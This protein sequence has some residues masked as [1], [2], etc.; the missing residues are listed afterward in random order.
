MKFY[1]EAYHT[2]REVRVAAI[3]LCFFFFFNF[4]SP[5]MIYP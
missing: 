1:E 4:V 5:F 3:S 2:L